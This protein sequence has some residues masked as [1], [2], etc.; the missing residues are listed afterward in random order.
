VIPN[1]RFAPVDGTDYPHLEQPKAFV[2]ILRNFVS[3]LH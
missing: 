3:T 2:D 1:A